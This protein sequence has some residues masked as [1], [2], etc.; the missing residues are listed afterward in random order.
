M[1]KDPSDTDA[2]FDLA[3]LDLRH[4]DLDEAQRIFRQLRS[5]HPDDLDARAGLGSTL[6]ARGDA[7]GAKQE[8]AAVLSASPTNF[9][10]LYGSAQI[11]LQ[12]SDLPTAEAM[13]TRA[14]AVRD[15]PDAHRLL[16]LAYAGNGALGKAVLEL[17][18]WKRL[19]PNDVEAHRAL[20]QVYQQL[21]KMP[22]ALKEEKAVVQ[23]TT[24][25]RKRLERS[26]RHG[27]AKPE[28]RSQPAATSNMPLTLEPGNEVAFKNLRRF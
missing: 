4:N 21:G 26:R 11:A 2:A 9:E 5:D 3:S 6:L 16:A 27:S 22:E 24:S 7:A 19:A 12:A 14:L 18:A 17:E 15:D 23:M 25:R 20:A 1:T 13:L 8:F 28:T 10:A